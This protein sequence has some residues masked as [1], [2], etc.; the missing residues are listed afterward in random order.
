MKTYCEHCIFASKV[1]NN[2]TG[3][4]MDRLNKYKKLGVAEK[5][6]NG[7]YIINEYCNACRNVY[8][9][10]YQECHT[11]GSLVDIV[12]KE[13]VIKYDV[14]I[15]INDC[16]ESQVMGC[17]NS[18]RYDEALKPN[19]IVLCGEL[20]KHNSEVIKS[21][22]TCAANLDISKDVF[23]Q[24]ERYTRKTTANYLL[25]VSPKTKFNGNISNINNRINQDLE[26]VFYINDDTYFFVATFLYKENIYEPNPITA[27]IE[28]WTEDGKPKSQHTDMQQ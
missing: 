20:N 28:K 25:L 24:S 10:K 26:R 1:G 22:P 23:S 6:E 14:I 7:K 2:Q 5:Q 13:T 9:D 16:S 11:I 27:I 21:F 15:N 8:W 4:L 12:N 3:C 17:V 19:K 18:F